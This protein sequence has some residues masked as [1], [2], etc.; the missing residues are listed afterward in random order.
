MSRKQNKVP[1]LTISHIAKAEFE[2]KTLT[3]NDEC[4]IFNCSS[5]NKDVEEFKRAS[6]ALILI[7]YKALRQIQSIL[8]KVSLIKSIVTDFSEGRF[9]KWE[10]EWSVTPSVFI[11]D[12]SGALMPF[13]PYERLLWCFN[14]SSADELPSDIGK[15]DELV[16]VLEITEQRRLAN[17]SMIKQTFSELLFEHSGLDQHQIN[18][19]FD[20]P[21][22]FS[23]TANSE[24]LLERRDIIEI[25]HCLDN[26]N[27]WYQEIIAMIRLRMP[28]TE[29]LSLF[30]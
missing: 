5:N 20:N 22:Y 14:S 21:E 9:T 8:E 24:S 27:A 4:L 17:I 18:S 26:Y 23:S 13:N 12:A 6:D 1:A 10:K 7:N 28:F 15:Y 16:Q 25:E 2:L 30:K 19:I 3:N 29:M 11:S